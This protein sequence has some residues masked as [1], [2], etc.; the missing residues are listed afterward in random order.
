MKNEYPI[1]NI[2][3][4]FLFLH[5]FP[6]NIRCWTFDVRCS[7]FSVNLPQSIRC[8]NNLALMGLAPTLH[9]AKDIPPLQDLPKT[10]YTLIDAH[11]VFYQGKPDVIVSVFSEAKPWRNSHL[12]FLD[13]HF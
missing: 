10:P 11:I 7:F 3:R 6:F 1:P 2:Q 8:K 12:G 4:L 13:Q 5:L 9:H